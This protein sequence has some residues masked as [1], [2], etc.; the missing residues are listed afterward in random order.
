LRELRVFKLQGNDPINDPD[1]KS[2]TLPALGTASCIQAWMTAL[3]ISTLKQKHK[4]CESRF[5][6]SSNLTILGLHLL[7]VCIRSSKVIPFWVY[8]A[9]IAFPTAGSI[10]G[11]PLSLCCPALPPIQLEP[12]Q[13]PRIFV[14][15]TGFASFGRKRNHNPRKFLSFRLDLAA[16][17]IKSVL[18][19]VA[20]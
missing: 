7:R 20:I 9:P 17:C 16:A 15:L 14:P 11:N 1:S 4:R 2:A 13:Y 10:S 12:P 8:S 19:A 18:F 3:L 6:C 5:T